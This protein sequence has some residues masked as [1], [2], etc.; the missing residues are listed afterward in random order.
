MALKGYRP[1][2]RFSIGSGR[3]I[4]QQW[5]GEK[6]RYDSL[7]PNAA[8][9]LILSFTN[10]SEV[11]SFFNKFHVIRTFFCASRAGLGSYQ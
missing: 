7:G 2:K 10:R 3:F 9:T 5:L 8:Q 1:L 6:N 11:T 4:R